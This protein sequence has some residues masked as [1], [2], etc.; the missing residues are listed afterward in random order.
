MKKIFVLFF[1]VTSLTVSAQDATNFNQVE[2]DSRLLELDEPS[3]ARNYVDLSGGKHWFVGV[4]GGTSAF[5]GSPK[6]CGDLYDRIKPELNAHI[7]KWITPRFGMRLAFQGLEY[8]DCMLNTRDYQAYHLDMLVNLANGWKNNTDGI[9]RWDFAPYVGFGFA[10]AGELSILASDEDGTM[11]DYVKSSHLPF[12]VSYGFYIRYRFSKHLH[13]IGDIGG[14]SS[15]KSFDGY[16]PKMSAFGDHLLS[17]SLG[18]GITF[19]NPKWKR[20]VDAAPYIAQ[21]YKLIEY[22][23]GLQ[24]QNQNLA[25]KHATDKRTI[26]ELRKILELEGL[27]EKYNYLFNDSIGSQNSYRGLESLRARMKNREENIQTGE[28]R[29][30]VIEDKP[31]VPIYFFFKRG[32]A[33][34]T[35]E[36]QLINLDE[37]ARVTNKYH[38]KLEIVGA[39]DAATGTPEI[40]SGLG[41]KRATFIADELKKRGVEYSEMHGLSAGGISEF[42]KPEQNRY[43][44]VS[45][46]LE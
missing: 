33:E 23:E 19:G 1:A 22:V 13:I 35:D 24:S 42:K 7:G 31:S 40:N 6:G 41:T 20:A 3:Y 32:K 4:M 26:T 27:L 16:T 8:K 36:S 46:F 38:L 9:A 15:S 10:N 28:R 21:S 25:S 45:I 34:L 29:D 43:T 39:A 30:I 11:T 5:I 18:F 12:I 17:A 14:I 37:L 2:I 44:R